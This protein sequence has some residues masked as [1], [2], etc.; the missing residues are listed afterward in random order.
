[1]KHVNNQCTIAG[2]EFSQLT[3]NNPNASG[4]LLVLPLLYF[5]GA[6]VSHDFHERA[7]LKS[8]LIPGQQYR[9]TRSAARYARLLLV[10]AGGT[11]A[12]RAGG[13]RLT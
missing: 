5:T 3:V 1:M 6:G 4:L 10:P 11:P 12:S 2:P 13:L 7:T 9:K 8:R